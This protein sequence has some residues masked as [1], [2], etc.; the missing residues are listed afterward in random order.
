MGA[1]IGILLT[2]GLVALAVRS[3]ITAIED[4]RPFKAGALILA[5]IVL[6]IICTSGGYLNV[7]SGVDV[8]YGP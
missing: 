8:N 2:L 4:R 1:V 5:I 7:N 3:L 6:L